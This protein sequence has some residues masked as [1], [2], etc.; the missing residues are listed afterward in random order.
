[1]NTSETWF[2]TYSGCPQGQVSSRRQSPVGLCVAALFFNFVAIAGSYPFNIVGIAWPIIGLW[3]L[4]KKLGHDAR[5]FKSDR[6]T[7]FLVAFQVP[8]CAFM[9][10]YMWPLD[11][12]I[13]L[14]KYGPGYT[15]RG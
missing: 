2:N 4:W 8:D 3:W 9:T 14:I 10:V 7:E 13:A 1:M 15:F 5:K 11:M 6:W 12:I